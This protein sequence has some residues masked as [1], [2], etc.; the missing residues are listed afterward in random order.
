MRQTDPDWS[1]TPSCVGSIF[2]CLI[3]DWVV[4]IESA[5]LESFNKN[6][7]RGASLLHNSHSS[8]VRAL[9][10]DLFWAVPIPV[11]QTE[12]SWGILKEIDLSKV[13]VNHS[14]HGKVNAISPNSFYVSGV[15]IMKLCRYSKLMPAFLSWI[16]IL[17]ISLK[18][19]SLL[20]KS[21]TT[22]ICACTPC[23]ETPDIL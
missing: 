22:D 10:T 7:Y 12:I 20:S 23:A 19:L 18:L 4:V 17:Y 5:P 1:L 8:N 2:Q 3:G 11:Q 14:K 6:N 21:P 9:W 16:F 13:L 15:E